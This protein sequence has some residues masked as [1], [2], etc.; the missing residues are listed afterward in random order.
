MHSTSDKCVHQ[1]RLERA[2][3]HWTSR[4]KQERVR[5]A[6]RDIKGKWVK[7]VPCNS[8]QSMPVHALAMTYMANTHTV[9]MALYKN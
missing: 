2:R 3:A 7:F 9:G 1:I 6:N 5:H 4:V 8:G